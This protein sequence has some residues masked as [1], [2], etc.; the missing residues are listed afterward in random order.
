MLYIFVIPDLIIS[1][2]NLIDHTNLHIIENGSFTKFNLKM[3]FLI[4]I[5]G[6]FLDFLSFK[7]FYIAIIFYGILYFYRSIYLINII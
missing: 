3:L 5:S 6:N 7:N 4:T 2:L 1:K